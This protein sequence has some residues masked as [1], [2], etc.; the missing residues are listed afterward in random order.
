MGYDMV[1]LSSNV[2]AGLASSDE[3]D[4]RYAQK[5]LGHASAEMTRRYRHLDTA[6]VFRIN[7]FKASGL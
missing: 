2:N 4:E 3:V 1:W 7:L 6:I 5:Q